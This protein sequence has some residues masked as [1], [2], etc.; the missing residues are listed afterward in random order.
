MEVDE[1]T[2]CYCTYRDGTWQTHPHATCE[3]RQRTDNELGGTEASTPQMEE[4]EKESEV[5]IDWE[6]ERETER[7]REQKR[8]FS[9]RLD[10]IP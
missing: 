5:E 4:S 6:M 8:Q 7:D 3:T 1:R 10:F 9:P 2:V